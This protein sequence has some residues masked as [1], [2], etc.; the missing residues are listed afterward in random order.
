[1]KANA[2]KY[3]QALFE[4]LTEED[5]NKMVAACDR[6]IELIDEKSVEIDLDTLTFK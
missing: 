2:S 1:M 6:F 3:S 4:I 5:K